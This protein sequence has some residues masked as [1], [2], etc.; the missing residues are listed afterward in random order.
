MQTMYRS[1]FS[2]FRASMRMYFRNKGAVF[3]TLVFP[4]ALLAVFGFISRG[5]GSSVKIDLTNQSLSPTAIQLVETLT[6]LPGF[7][8][9]QNSESEGRTRLEKGNTDVQV[10]IPPI[11]GEKLTTGQPQPARHRGHQCAV[12]TPVSK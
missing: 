5:N 7:S 9:T 1:F 4:I 3:F 10:I 6:Q 2:L 11:F 12:L 8:I